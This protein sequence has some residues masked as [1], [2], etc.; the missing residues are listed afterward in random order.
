MRLTERE[1]E[2]CPMCN[3]IPPKLV[4]MYDNDQ[5]HK[6]TKCCQDCKRKVKKGLPIEKFKRMED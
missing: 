4:P 3:R 1:N 5:A 2:K 6:N